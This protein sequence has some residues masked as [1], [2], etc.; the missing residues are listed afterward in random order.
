[1][2]GHS[3]WATTKHKKGAADAKRGQAFSKLAK[4][5]TVAAREGADPDMNFALRLAVDRAKAVNMPKDNIERAIARGAGTGEGGALETAV[6][7][8]MGPGGVAML[9]VAL[10]DNTNRAYTNIKTIANKSGGNMEAKVLWQFSQKGIVRVED[11]SAVEDRDSIELALIDAGAE[12]IDWN[13]EVG[14]MI[15]SE[16]QDLKKVSDAARAAGLAITS[17]GIEYVPNSTIELSD[18]DGEKLA[19]FVDSIEEDDDVD[20]VYTNAA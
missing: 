17:A 8:C 4:L 19:R 2:S 9:I 15:T 13:E 1:M 14:L 12:D 3:K 5:I 7:E 10:T 11:I 20:A 16:V 6:Y 18:E